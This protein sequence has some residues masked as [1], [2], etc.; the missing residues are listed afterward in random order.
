[1][2]TPAEKAG[3]MQMMQ[4]S[5][6]GSSDTVERSLQTFLDSTGVDE[7]MIASH[8]YDLEARMKSLDRVAAI[9]SSSVTA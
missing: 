1:V 2:W 7:I 5:F 8:V 6:I 4:Y 3:V 9:F